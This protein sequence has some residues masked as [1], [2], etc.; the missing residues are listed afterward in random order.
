MA[1]LFKGTVSQDFWPFF[2]LSHPG[3]H[4][5][6]KKRFRE[7]FSFC[8]DICN[9]YLLTT[10]TWCWCGR[11]CASVVNDYAD[12]CQRSR[13]Q[14]WHGKLFYFPYLISRSCL[15]KICLPI[16]PPYQ[17]ILT[18]EYISIKN[19]NQNLLIFIPPTF[20]LES[21]N[22]NYSAPIGSMGNY[23]LST[24]EFYVKCTQ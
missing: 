19:T 20:T 23:L 2:G 21:R 6:R 9:Y 11:N 12:T 1:V 17:C 15:Y 14:P 16:N 7:I 18:K 5:N 13:W 4:I 22:K 8:K 3:P 10:L 24:R